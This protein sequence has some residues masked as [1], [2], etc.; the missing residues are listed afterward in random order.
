MPRLTVSVHDK[1]KLSFTVAQ[2]GL[3]AL[4]QRTE[5]GRT[6]VAIA[7]EQRSGRRR[8][9]LFGGHVLPTNCTQPMECM[10]RDLSVSGASLRVS[11]AASNSFE[12]RVERDGSVRHAHTI[13]QDGDLRGVVFDDAPKGTAE[14]TNVVSI[15]DLRRRLRFTSDE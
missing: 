1:F 4:V 12:L 14:A 15:L 11:A 2:I 3:M 9:V 7:R 10:V 8:R 6:T 5:F 13:W